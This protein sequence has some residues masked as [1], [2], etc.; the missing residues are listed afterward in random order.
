[1]Y[2]VTLTVT[3]AQ[4]LSDQTSLTIEVSESPDTNDVAMYINAGGADN[5]NLE[6]HTF[7]GDKNTP[8][9]YSGNYT[10]EDTEASPSSLY[11]IERGPGVNL[12]TL[13]YAIP[14]PNGTYTISTYHAELWWGKKG[15]NATAGKRVFDIL[16]ELPEYDPSESN[17]PAKN[18]R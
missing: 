10:Y 11:R 16:I 6:G 9:I 14:V 17:I 7:V 8:S 5:V 1:T 13:N 4:G 3:D 15:G 12:G 18:P 2:P